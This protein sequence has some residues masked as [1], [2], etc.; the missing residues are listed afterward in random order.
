MKFYNTYTAFVNEAKEAGIDAIAQSV[1]SA[2][3]KF[4]KEHYRDSMQQL[5][6][7]INALANLIN[8]NKISKEQARS[9]WDTINTPLYNIFNLMSQLKQSKKELIQTVILEFKDSLAVIEKYIGELTQHQELTKTIGDTPKAAEP[10]KEE[11]KAEQPE[12]KKSGFVVDGLTP[13]DDAQ[14]AEYLEIA[15]KINSL[16]TN[17]T[18][19]TQKRNIQTLLNKLINAGLKVDG[20]FGKKSIQAAAKLKEAFLGSGITELST[21]I[22]ADKQVQATAGVNGAVD[23]FMRMGT[24]RAIVKYLGGNPDQDIVYIDKEDDTAATADGSKTNTDN[25]TPKSDMKGDVYAQAKK[26]LGGKV[27]KQADGTE[28]L[29]DKGIQYYQKNKNGQ[30][31]FFNIDTK[32]KGN[33]TVTNGI[34]VKDGDHY[35]QLRLLYPNGKVLKSKDGAEVFVYDGIQYYQKNKNGEYRFFNTKTKVRGSYTTD[36]N[37][38]KIELIEDDTYTQLKALYPKADIQKIPADGSERVVNDG[39]WYFQKNKKGEYRFHNPKTKTNGN[40]SVV[41]DK[42]VLKADG[43]NKANVTLPTMRGVG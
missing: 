9:T 27:I 22:A 34:V 43:S 7:A 38:K 12:T 29:V 1:T 4:G 14:K 13:L 23:G 32:A 16:G 6:N 20:F 35:A 3:D 17:T 39:I 10:A 24:I 36:I 26:I 40:Y 28:L 37:S 11:K 33:Y 41:N 31:R 19:E 18:D 21:E 2:N 25:G 5:S 8:T 42:V 15:K 30:Y